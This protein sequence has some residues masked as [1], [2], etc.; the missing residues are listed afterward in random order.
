LVHS[1]RTDTSEGNN[2]APEPTA[3][4]RSK[5]PTLEDISRVQQ[6]DDGEKSS[7]SKPSPEPNSATAVKSSQSTT[8][9]ISRAQQRD[10]GKKSSQSNPSPEPRS[11]DGEKLPAHNRS[12]PQSQASITTGTHTRSFSDRPPPPLMAPLEPNLEETQTNYLSRWEIVERLRQQWWS[13]WSHEYLHQLQSRAKWRSKSS[14]I[15]PGKMVVIKEDNVPPLLWRLGCIHDLHP[16][17]D[18]AVRVVTIKTARG[19]IK[20]AVHKVCPLPIVD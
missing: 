2:P 12:H 11:D 3:R 14:D 9:E 15:R 7:Q 13:R 6:R 19:I 5:I 17:D 1:S 10:D 20:R 18:G 16:G 4:R 8:E